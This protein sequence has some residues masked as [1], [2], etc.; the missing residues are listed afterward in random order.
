MEQ[1]SPQ[2]PQQRDNKGRFMKGFVPWCKGLKGEEH[3]KHYKNGYAKPTL[4]KHH[5]EEWKKNLSDRIK[6]ENHPMFGKH[7]SKESI[8]KISENKKGKCVGKDN[9]FYGKHHSLETRRKMSLVGKGK[10]SWCKGTKG[11]LK[12]NKTSFK[13]G[14]NRTPSGKGHPNWQGGKTFEPYGLSWT[15]Q[16]KESIRDR[17]NNVCQLCKK[18]QIQLK[19]KLSVHHIDYIKTN[20][21]TFNLISLCVN[22]HSVTNYNK[23]HWTT[24]F[25]NYLSEKYGYNYIT[26]QKIILD[27]MEV[28]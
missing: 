22:C 4:G 25:R 15:K 13:K 1:P 28:K 12:P 3:K 5:T 10:T 24:F 2:M 19:R 11:I 18:H 20:V 17:D 23:N 9:P 8:K 27:F 14:H 6:G 26:N 21:F 7:H 16:F